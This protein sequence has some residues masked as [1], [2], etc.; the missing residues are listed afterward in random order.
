MATVV[1]VARLL[2][3]V[4]EETQM[5]QVAMAM[6]LP[7][8]MPLVHRA[9]VHRAHPRLPQLHLAL[10][11]GHPGLPGLLGRLTQR[12]DVVRVRGA[13]DASPLPHYLL[14]F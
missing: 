7:M 2:Q 13:G 4:L 1:V 6:V 14:F 3:V 11:L 10:L 9:R 5:P 12:L 8:P